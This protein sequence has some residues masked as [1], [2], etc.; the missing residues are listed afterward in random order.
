MMKPW[1]KY[2]QQQAAQEQQAASEQPAGPWLKYQKLQEQEQSQPEEKT[3]KR[4][5]GIVAAPLEAM[6]GFNRAVTG[7]V[8]FLGPDQVNA[9]LQLAGSEMR[10]PTLTKALAPATQGG[11]MEP[12]LGRDVAASA[13]EVAAAGLGTGQILRSA[14]QRLPQAAAGESVGRGALRQMGSSTPVQDLTAGAAAGAGKVIG[15][16]HGGQVGGLIGSMVAPLAASPALLS[17]ARSAAGEAAKRA[18][19]GGASRQQ[20]ANTIDD[21]AKAGS[22]PTL[23]QA[24]GRRAIQQTENLA[25][26][27]VGGGPIQ[28]VREQIE[29]GMQQRLRQIADDISPVTGVER[30]GRTIQRGIS[31]GYGNRLTAR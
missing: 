24:T 3:E 4:L 31:A 27:L 11:F 15:E 30:A 22:T 6:A 29:Q 25:G 19:R 16:E 5:P 18:F 12:G 13:G 14:A 1:E 20:V 8:D 2:A 9:I 23:G 21:F 17:G 26:Q 7:L 28:K 10:M